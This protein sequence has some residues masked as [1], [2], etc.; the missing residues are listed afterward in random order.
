MKKILFSLLITFSVTLIYSQKSYNDCL[1][2]FPICELGTYYFN[3]I[4]DIIGEK[5]HLKTRC[6]NIKIEET[7]PMWFKFQVLSDGILTF[8]INPFEEKDDIDFILYQ[9]VNNE[10]DCETKEDIRCM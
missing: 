3:S 5:D 2:S 1:T 6:L 9:H 7:N 10:F 4:E 8:V